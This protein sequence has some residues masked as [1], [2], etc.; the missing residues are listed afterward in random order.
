MSTYK[1]PTNV[2]AEMTPNPTT[3]K[4][5]ADRPLVSGSHQLEFLSPE[6][7]ELCSPLAV[8]LFHFP[9]V[10][11]VF[12]SGS[13]VAVTKDESL[14]WEMIVNQ[15]REYIREWLMENEFAVEEDK[16]EAALE[17]LGE[18]SSDI[19]LDESAPPINFIKDTD[20]KPSKHDDEIK[21]LLNEFVRPAVEQDGGAIDFVAFK[22]GVVYVHLRGACSGCPSSTQTLKGGIEQLLKSKLE[23]VEEVV[24][25]GV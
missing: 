13:I 8:E 2:Y 7:A 1:I 15:L 17:M 19:V 20:I 25:I 12:I 23:A 3:M 18:A 5:V 24:A 22:D 9:F 11:G 6:K 16:V 4:F 14:G 21:R 10:T